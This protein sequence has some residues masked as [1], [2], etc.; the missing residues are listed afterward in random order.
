MSDGLSVRVT[1]AVECVASRCIA[2]GTR[3]GVAE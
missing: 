1:D 2:P 3:N